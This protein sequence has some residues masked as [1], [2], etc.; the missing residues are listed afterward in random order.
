MKF[1]SL[2]DG[3]FINQ[4]IKAIA[5]AGGFVLDVGGGERF[6]KWL[7]PYEPLFKN[8]RFQTMDYDKQTGADVVGDIHKIPLADNS[9]DSVICHSVLEHVENPPQAMMEIYRILKSGGQVFVHVPSTYPYH[10]RKGAYPDLW[11]IF[12]DTIPILFKNFKEVEFAKRGGYFKALFFF[13]P[14]QHKMRFIIDPLSAF[15]DKLFRTKQRHTT[16]G[17]YIYAIK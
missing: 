12:D 9:V 1:S 17:Y 4:K 7:T 13:L 16:A 5:T 15:L 8:C 6:Q 10:A 11:R 14:F 2:S 3:K